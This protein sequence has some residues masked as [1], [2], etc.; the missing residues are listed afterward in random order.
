M[1]EYGIDAMTQQT[2]AKEASVLA[3][4]SRLG[5]IK[6]KSIIDTI[7][8]FMVMGAIGK[9]MLGNSQEALD[10]KRHEALV[11][12][13]SAIAEARGDRLNISMYAEPGLMA[14]G[15]ATAS[16]QDVKECVEYIGRVVSEHERHLTKEEGLETRWQD[17]V[18]TSEAGPDISRSR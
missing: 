13:A 17:K 6:E 16:A 4:A 2:R 10:R 18:R 15:L 9:L 1:V 7:T 14:A 11:R 8:S 12:T 3:S 5:L